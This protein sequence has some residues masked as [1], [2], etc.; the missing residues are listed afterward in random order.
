MCNWSRSEN[1]K[2]ENCLTSN[3]CFGYEHT[4]IGICLLSSIFVSS[5][6]KKKMCTPNKNNT[7]ILKHLKRISL[8]DSKTE[9]KYIK[10]K[11]KKRR[12]PGVM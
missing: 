3:M 1:S 8:I 6:K 2:N 11:E 4:Q 12:I 10:K 9:E 5:K 7:Y